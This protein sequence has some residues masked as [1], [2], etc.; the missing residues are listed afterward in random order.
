M[1]DSHLFKIA[2]ECSLQSD[3]CGHAKI[4]CIIV[5]KGCVL[6]KGFNTDKTHTM[7]DKFNVCRYKNSG[8][9]YL[10]SKCH[11]EIAALSKVKYL[12]IEWSKVHIYVYRELKDGHIAMSKPCAACLSAIKKM[13]IKHIHYTSDDGFCHEYLI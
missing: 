8:N 13:G 2:R 11:S 12:D 3:Y 9:R 1:D 5:Y 4:G 7:Q 10:P 6:A